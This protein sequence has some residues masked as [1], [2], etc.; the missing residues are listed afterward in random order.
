MPRSNFSFPALALWA[1]LLSPWFPAAAINEPEPEPTNCPPLLPSFDE[2]SGMRFRRIGLNGVPMSAE[3]EQSK[4]ESDE[5]REESYVDS[6]SLQLRHD[7]SDIYVPLSGGEL[8]LA[9]KR[10]AAGEMWSQARDGYYGDNPSEHLQY[11]KPF[12]YG[13]SSGIGATLREEGYLTLTDSPSMCVSPRPTPYLYAVD[14]NGTSYKFARSTLASAEDQS[15]TSDVEELAS[16]GEIQAA[17]L[18]LPSNRTEKANLFN[19][20]IASYELDPATGKRRHGGFELTRKFGTKLKYEARPTKSSTIQLDKDGKSWK[21]ISYRRLLS[22]ED[23]FGNKLQFVFNVGNSSLIPDSIVVE[24]DQ[25]TKRAL[26]IEHSGGQV[27]AVVDPRGNRWSYSYANSGSGTNAV[28]TLTS[29]TRP[30]GSRI[31]YG[32]EKV[33]VEDTAPPSSVSDPKPKD[34]FHHINLSKITSNLRT[35]DPVLE[36]QS[37]AN[38]PLHEITIAYQADATTKAPGL[39]DMGDGFAVVDYTPS[40][41]RPRI[42]STTTVTGAGT[43]QFIPL[44]GSNA[45]FP[46]IWPRVTKRADGL[47]SDPEIFGSRAADVVDAASKSRR[48]VY[49]EGILINSRELEE[50][51]YRSGPKAP[52]YQV[53]WKNC[54]LTQPGGGTDSVEFDTT[55]GMADKIVTDFSG[56]QTTYEYADI[57][58]FSWALKAAGWG[59]LVDDPKWSV[60]FTRVDNLFSGHYNDPTKET[61]AFSNPVT[62]L[63][64]T[65]V[66]TFKYVTSLG[67]P[68]AD[69]PAKH[70]LPGARVMKE[71][72]DGEN[73]RTVYTVDTAT[74]NRLSETVFSA[75]GA[76]MKFTEFQYD[77]VFKGFPTRTTVHNANH[78]NGAFSHA[79]TLN[80]PSTDGFG[81]VG[82]SIVDPDGLNL[83]TSHTYDPNGNRLTTTDPRQNT[84][85]F[86]YDTLNRLMKTTF[87]DTGDGATHKAFAYNAAGRKLVERDENGHWSLSIYDAAGRPVRAIRDLDGNKIESA[88]DLVTQ[89]TYNALGQPVDAIDARG[90]ITRTA[91]DDLARPVSTTVDPG[92]LNLVTQMFYDGPNSGAKAFSGYGFK[93]TRMVDPRGFETLIDYDGRYL[94]VRTR[95][96]Y[97]LSPAKYAVVAQEYDLAGNEILNKAWRVEGDDATVSVTQTTY[98]ALNRP[99][100][101]TK[102]YGTTLAATTQ[103]FY[104][105]VAA[106]RTLDP[107]NRETI[108]DY[109]AAGRAVKAWSPDPITGQ[110]NRATPASPVSGSGVTTTAYDDANNPV[111]VTDVLGRVTTT[112][113]DARNRK[114]FVTAPTHVYQLPGG[115]TQSVTPVTESRYD[116]VGNVVRTIDPRQVVTKTDYDRANR[117]TTVTR[118]EG[119]AEVAITGTYYDAN[120]NAVAVQDANGNWTRN[121]YDRAN[122]LT[123]TSVNPL[124]GEPSADPAVPNARD[125]IVR[126]EYDAGGNLI[127]VTDGENQ[128]TAFQFDG[129]ARKIATVWDPG[130]P[131]QRTDSFVFDALVQVSRTDAKGQTVEFGYDALL[132]N[133]TISYVGRSADNRVHAYDLAGNLLSVTYPNE[134]TLNQSIR[135]VAQTFDALNRAVTEQ[136]NG[137]T[138][139]HTFDKAGN[140]LLIEYGGTG[141]KL[142]SRYDAFNKLEVCWDTTAAVTD[143]VGYTGQTGDR[144]TDYVYDVSG[145]PLLK[146]LPNGDTTQSTYDALNRVLVVETTSATGSLISKFDYSQKAL[147]TLAADHSSG[148][149]RVGNVCQVLETVPNNGSLPLRTVVNTYD[150]TSRLEVEYQVEQ[151]ISGYNLT[152]HH[153]SRVYIY[154]NAHNRS[155]I[156]EYKWN[157]AESTS[158]S[159]YSWAPRAYSL[160]DHPS[161]SYSRNVYDSNGLTLTPLGV[162]YY[163]YGDGANGYNS[164][165]LAYVKGTL[166]TGKDVGQGLYTYD[167]NGNRLTKAASGR[168]DTY[169]YDFDNRLVSLE[170]NTPA[171]TAK[172][173]TYRYA[174]DHRTRRVARDESLANG[175]KRRLVFSGGLSVQEYATDTISTANLKVENIRGNDL[176]GGIGGVLYTVRGSAAA[177]N[178]YNSRGDVIAQSDDAGALTWQASY[179]AFGTRT[180]EVG[181]NADRQRAN[182]KDEDPTGL[183]NEGFRYRDLATGMFITRDPAGFVDGP[184]VYTYVRQNPWTAFDPDGLFMQAVGNWLGE[185]WQAPSVVRSMA[186]HTTTVVNT[187]QATLTAVSTVPALG[188]V[189]D[190]C[191]ASISAAEGNYGEATATLTAGKA[192]SLALKGVKIAKTAMVAAVVVEEAA[193]KGDDVVEIAVKADN[194]L[195]ATAR[196]TT[197]KATK[198]VDDVLYHYTDEAGAKGIAETGVIK[199]DAKGRVYLTTDKVAPEEASDALFMG[200]GGA[201]GTHRVDVR[202]K[203]QSGGGLSTGTQPNEIIHEGAVRDP[204]NATMEVKENDFGNGAGN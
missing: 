53:L 69:D 139:A 94:P 17:Y 89:T 172:R 130:K 55:A 70:A 132:R 160:S 100:A 66:K 26:T 21:F 50:V 90:T 129:L 194:A 106:Y 68:G 202:L 52:S 110:V 147:G 51:L 158:G 62:G 134:S 10:S 141:R 189:A 49:G 143:P 154:D 128:S 39:V 151:Y 4:E 91:Y 61:R 37:I 27:T 135:G 137:V 48:F 63:Q 118:A 197:E 187:T 182:T 2:T 25:G 58:K 144:R 47:F 146:R 133:T 198:E 103:T 171:D 73:R 23:R 24:S 42:V 109:D 162:V 113:Y 114:R 179:E 186:N 112:T 161:S 72:V 173:G 152:A 83:T 168:V 36:G 115:G 19:R 82:Q 79:V 64:Q 60:Y 156:R 8:A 153:N 13:W 96:Q 195:T 65:S 190:V 105:P 101:V 3:K 67:E 169:A 93:P 35:G 18:P 191:S 71:S 199:P 122:R 170:L 193:K 43:A 56:N 80:V 138:H 196:E 98:D 59:N 142:V 131:A 34:I 149:D 176:G 116:A 102:A 33:S 167:A 119:L 77:S 28:K 29:V 75:T 175:E 54:V 185:R 7:T 20:L 57:F 6:L 117:P 22:A 136:S 148:Y 111:S 81:Y 46:Q 78:S 92:G 200:R 15:G 127:K 76:M 165:Q 181:S 120:G 12:G 150:R 16:A 123:S 164:N 192:A 125:I 99:T 157:S 203:D 38:G 9:V 84:T 178:S 121:V 30:D 204:R 31:E 5:M 155:E 177:F 174:Y 159:E 163:F 107:L 45:N 41:S 183:L 108:T 188:K 124:T 166:E 32:Y 40:S 14:E 87:P 88:G 104:G 44:N 97:Q 1:L 74:G 201:K 86:D 11:D 95:K 180:K 85:S 184:N 140:R 145:N 126:N